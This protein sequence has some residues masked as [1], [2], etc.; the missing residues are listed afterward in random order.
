MRII[1]DTSAVVNIVMQT[2]QAAPLMAQLASAGVVFAPEFMRIELAN[3]L[4][5]AAQFANLDA[6]LVSE[7][8]TT[9]CDLVDQFVGDAALVQHALSLSLQWK[10]P[11]YDMLFIA[12]CQQHGACLLTRDRKLRAVAEKMGAGLCVPES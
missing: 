3:A 7:R 1:L 9:G 6:V 8:F 5:K 2:E 11:V 10:H 4:W 12:A